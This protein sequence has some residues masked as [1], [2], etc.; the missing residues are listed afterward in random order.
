MIKQAIVMVLDQE[1][2]QDHTAHQANLAEV[3]AAK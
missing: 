3:D 2:K 1:T